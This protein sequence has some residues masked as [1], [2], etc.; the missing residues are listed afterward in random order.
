[1]AAFDPERPD[2][3]PDSARSKVPKRT[4]AVDRSYRSGLSAPR[5]GARSGQTDPLGLSCCPRSRC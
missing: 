3:F 4:L 1:V 5:S 2:D